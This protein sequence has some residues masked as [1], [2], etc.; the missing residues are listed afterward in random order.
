VRPLAWALLIALSGCVEGTTVGDD[1]SGASGAGSADLARKSDRGATLRERAL[2][3]GLEA[4]VSEPPRPPENPL[5]SDRVELGH[6]LFFDPILSG[7]EDVACSTCHLPRFGFADGRQ[8]GVGA[9]GAGLGPDRTL[10]EP[11]LRQMPR[12]SP[13]LLNAGLYGRGGTPP[14]VNGMMFWGGTA[15]GVEDQVLNPLTSDKEMRGLTYS[16]VMA[17]D[18]VLTRLRGIPEYVERFRAAYPEVAS[19][20]SDDPARLITTTTLRR[21]LAAYI[22]ELVTPDSPFDR[23]L[24]GEDEALTEDQQVGLD[25]YIGA[26]GCVQCHSGPLLSDFSHHVIGAAQEGLGRDTI[27][28]DDLGWGEAGGVAYAFRTAP[29]RQV[30]QTAP[31]FHAGTAATLEDVIRFKASARSAQPKV[32]DDDLDPLVQP[33]ELT[34]AEVDR[35]VAFLTSL[36]DQETVQ[37]PLFLA[38]ERVPS[39]LE[40]P[41]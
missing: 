34:D 15:F 12:N 23:F 26:A 10:P 32:A 27:P 8:F 18:S 37:G 17:L 5:N 19:V 38:P 28:G 29:L 41:K 24:R 7:P 4:I 21:A 40:V 30:D 3:A 6:R 36:T 14:S 13:T 33:L 22:R 35:L 9:G 39:G 1:G 2:A 25:L 20:H 16:K 11:P 31:Y